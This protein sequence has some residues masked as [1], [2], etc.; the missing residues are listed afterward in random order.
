MKVF[1]FQ[2]YQLS[3]MQHAAQAFHVGVEFTKKHYHKN[4]SAKR[5]ADRDKTVIIKS[6]GTFPDVEDIFKLF[7]SRQNS[8]PFAEFREPDIFNHITSV[9]ICV[10]A[11]IYKHYK[12][13][14]DFEK[15]LI[16]LLKRTKLAG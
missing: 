16:S 6:G 7:K 15:E 12:A 1:A 5:W 2:P 14:N 13:E 10:P 4:K 8:F 11:R 3:P 9:A